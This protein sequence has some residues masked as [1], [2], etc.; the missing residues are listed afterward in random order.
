M[1]RDLVDPVANDSHAMA[2]MQDREDMTTPVRHYL[3]YI[4]RIGNSDGGLYP[5]SDGRVFIDWWQAHRPGTGASDLRHLTDLADRHGVTLV[6][7]AQRAGLVRYA[8]RFGFVASPAPSTDWTELVRSPKTQSVSSD[9]FA[10]V[11]SLAARA[12]RAEAFVSEMA[13]RRQRGGRGVC[14]GG[15]APQIQ[16]F[17]GLI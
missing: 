12:V 13:E 17:R 4:R 7:L 8:R 10:F 11:A 1:L 14:S 3:P 6:R 15:G 16:T 9:D 5:L 2:F